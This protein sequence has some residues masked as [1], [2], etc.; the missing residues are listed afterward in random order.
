MELTKED[1]KI[2]NSNI[3]LKH[4]LARKKI[5]LAK[6]LEEVRFEL[7]LRE[8]Q[9]EL[10]RMQL[11]IIEN[12]K[13]LMVLFHGGDSSEKSGIIRKILSHNNPRHYRVEVNLPHRSKDLQ[14]EWYFKKFVEKLPQG[15]EMV[16]WDRSWY[17]RAIIEPVHG[18]CSKDEYEQFMGQ[19]NEFESMLTEAGIT[20]V[21]FYFNISKKEQAKRLKEIKSSHLTKWKM[22]PL[23]EMSEGLWE[24]YQKHKEIMVAKTHT[25][26]APW[27][28]IK[29]ERREE[30]L[31]TAARHIL[32]LMPYK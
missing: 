13:K 23:D 32:S 24:E 19:V 22:T 29:K 15:G 5:D 17:N 31:I 27:I 2:L 21:K 30:E 11:W 10:V 9:A 25:A 7:T 12:N 18:L 28:E 4:L 8:I 6:V 14:G 26:H 20:L 16:F 3:G 1:I